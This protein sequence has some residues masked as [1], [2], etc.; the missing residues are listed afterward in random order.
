MTVKVEYVTNENGGWV[1]I[2]DFFVS[3]PTHSQHLLMDFGCLGVD[4]FTY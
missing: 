4:W 3:L 2:L 1:G